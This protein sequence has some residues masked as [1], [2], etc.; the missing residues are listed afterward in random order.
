MW[1]EYEVEYPGATP[2]DI[3]TLQDFATDIAFDIDGAYDDPIAAMGTVVTYLKDLSGGLKDDGRPELG[4][5][6]MH[7]VWANAI[8]IPVG[9]WL[10]QRQLRVAFLAPLVLVLFG[11]S[12]S[13]IIARHAVRYQTAW[14]KSVQG[15]TGLTSVVLGHIK[16]LRVSGLTTPAS[17][18]VKESREDEL[19]VGGWSRTIV[20]ISASFSQLPQAV[21]PALAFAFGPHSINQTQAFT[22]LS[23]LALLTSP[24]LMVLQILPIISASF[25]CLK[26]IKVFLDKQDRVDM[27]QIW[28]TEEVYDKT[29]NSE[30]E[31]GQW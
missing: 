29:E 12:I 13:F 16:D 24:L 30:K 15:R 25:A 28:S 6:M 3:K 23:L 27:R 4:L 14:M 2:Y 22:S 18:L 7:E 1:K 17:T 20:G 11:F 26:R 31:P 5:R 10:L 21:A 19:K 9:L 8:Q